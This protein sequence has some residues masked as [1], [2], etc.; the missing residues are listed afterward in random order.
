MRKTIAVLTN[1]MGGAKLP[2]ERSFVSAIADA[3]KQNDD[4][5]IFY[6]GGFYNTPDRF[7]SQRNF[8]YE[9]VER[10]RPDG[11]IMLS[12]LLGEFCPK[13][14]IYALCKTF[15]S[16]PLVSS[17]M[18]V[19]GVPSVLIN[20][21]VAMRSVTDHVFS[22]NTPG[23]I[24]YLGGPKDGDEAQERF[25]A[26]S[27]S[28]TNAGYR[29]EDVRIFE[30]I[31]LKISGCNAALK[32]LEEDTPFDTVISASDEMA[33]GFVEC[34][35][36][37]GIRCPDDFRI[38]GF[39]NVKGASLFSPALTTVEQ[40]TYEMG[41]ASFE[42]LRRIIIG[43]PAQE[44]TW[45]PTRLLIR[46]SCGCGGGAL[47]EIQDRNGLTEE[48]L[49]LK[50]ESIRQEQ[51]DYSLN[52]ISEGLFNTNTEGQLC[53]TLNREI[54]QLREIISCSLCDF[55]RQGESPRLRAFIDYSRETGARV[56]D[57]GRWEGRTDMGR[58]SGGRFRVVESL[59]YANEVMGVI[60]FECNTL[61]Y[62]A[63]GILREQI[64]LTL[65]NIKTFTRIA[66]LNKSLS[67]EVSHLS[68]LR[69]IDRAITETRTRALLLDVL[70]NE[71]L[72]Q[73]KTDAIVI[74]LVH[75]EGSEP[76]I[77]AWR[78]FRRLQPTGSRPVPAQRLLVRNLHQAGALGAEEPD[79]RNYFPEEGFSFYCR[80]PLCAHGKT[81][82]LVE[83]FNRSPFDSTPGWEAF[84]DTLAG[85]AAIALDNARLM[86]DLTQANV[87]LRQAYNTTIE[88]WSRA[89][90]LRD[91]ETEGHCMRVAQ[92]S[93]KL[94]KALGLPNAEIENLYRG[95]LLHDIGK[96]G[97]PDAILLKPGP[98]SDDE[99]SIMSLHPT[100][101][102]DLLSPIEY[103]L[104][105][106]AVPWCHHEKWDGTGYPQGLTGED[107][108][109]SA[110]IFAVIDV[111]DALSSERP[112]RG[113]WER[114]QII[115]HIK[116]QSGSHFDPSVVDAFLALVEKNQEI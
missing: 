105:S 40:N 36:E 8:V 104:P 71:I 113:P 30:G 110:R 60:I 33:F 55:R 28:L 2:Y 74:S 7:E 115:A 95:A 72:D 43:E 107:I 54:P 39:D 5:V 98:L 90:D 20:N 58:D 26:F 41:T 19:P 81:I 65:H 97:I 37:H 47:P 18:S 15:G 80:V 38:T 4:K 91:H 34:M 48:I 101:A 111:W 100:Y 102:Y 99:R 79:I 69:T 89:L 3:A 53:A 85:Q 62:S 27:D 73:Q 42:A 114:G 32:L 108:P 87:S 46:D 82:G 12:S 61:P 50:R 109:L 17:G 70:M 49:N 21:Y 112:Y 59:N 14:D 83:L 16:I 66:E 88:G 23:K 11:I 31:Y 116:E 45:L 51:E 57:E 10:D 29:L 77:A 93:V 106:L 25:R 24:V 75:Q 52:I 35:E 76:E 64:S 84:L 86:E 6:S 103:L 22:V 56:H 78:G 1:H 67:E 92:M 9:L 44:V 94:G 13:K 68:S 63:F 96:V